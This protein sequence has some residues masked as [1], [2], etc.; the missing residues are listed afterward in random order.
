MTENILEVLRRNLQNTAVRLGD[1]GL[2]VFLTTEG[3]KISKLS[4]PQNGQND[5]CR[6]S[7]A[8]LISLFPL[9]PDINICRIASK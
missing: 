9:R 2:G 8:G 3:G 5:L 7:C 1:G 4:P 6:Q